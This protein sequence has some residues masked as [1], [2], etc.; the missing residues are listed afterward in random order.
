[1]RLEKTFHLSADRE[2]RIVVKGQLIKGRREI[3]IDYEFLIREKLDTDFRP[4]IG[5]NHPQYWK[6]KNASSQK[7]QLLQLAYSG[8]SR[9]QLKDATK[10]FKRNIGG[11]FLF[12]YQERDRGT[13]QVP[14]GH[15]RQ[16]IKPK[17]AVGC[18]A[19]V[20]G[21]GVKMYATGLRIL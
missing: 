12:R 21:N 19:G 7:S 6:L 9:K 3:I 14:Q 10:E 2:A 8:I 4:P 17:N 16:R 20:V 18:L 5:I 13:Y 11:D 1:M 15:P